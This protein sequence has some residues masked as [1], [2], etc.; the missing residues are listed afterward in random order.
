M[1]KFVATIAIVIV[2]VAFLTLSSPAVAAPPPEFNTFSVHGRVTAIITQTEQ[3]GFTVT[4]VND[5][6]LIPCLES[7]PV[8]NCNKVEVNDFVKVEGH[9]ATYIAASD[10]T[11]HNVLV[12]DSLTWREAQ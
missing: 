8:F 3:V 7:A 2:A 12:L 1:S 9:F 10:D 4:I 5:E 6:I 11:L